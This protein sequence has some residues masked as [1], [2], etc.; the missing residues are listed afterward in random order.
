VFIF[1]HNPTVSELFSDLSG[2]GIVDLPTCSVS[3]FQSDQSEWKY[4][5]ASKTALIAQ[6]WPK[7]LETQGK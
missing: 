3:I 2:T 7:L 5:M 6:F 4:T 1:G